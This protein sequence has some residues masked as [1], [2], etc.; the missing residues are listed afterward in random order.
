MKHYILCFIIVISAFPVNSCKKVDDPP[1]YSG[2]IRRQTTD[3]TSDNGYLFVIKVDNTPLYDSFYTSTLPDIFWPSI[4]A[5]IKFRVREYA[6]G[7]NHILCN[8]AIIG[9]K[10]YFIYDVS[11]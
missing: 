6:S 1:I 10:F 7:E 2:Q 5:K 8:T 9:P 3:C 11:K 4:G